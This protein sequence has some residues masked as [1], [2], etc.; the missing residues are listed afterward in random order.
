MTFNFGGFID[1]RRVHTDKCPQNETPNREQ[2]EL[3][4][5]G[6]FQ[7]TKILDRQV[8]RQR[9]ETF[10]SPACSYNF[11]VRQSGCCKFMHLP[12]CSL[13]FTLSVS[14][15][16]GSDNCSVACQVV[17]FVC[18]PEDTG[19]CKKEKSVVFLA[20]IFGIPLTAWSFLCSRDPRI[21]PVTISPLPLPECIPLQITS[22]E[23][24]HKDI[25][26]SSSTGMRFTKFTLKTLAW[27][28]VPFLAE[29]V[30]GEFT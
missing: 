15:W 26:T 13:P 17:C 16:N 7:V 23:G 28:I 11:F 8:L 18:I 22:C 4:V 12:F 21:N 5:R 27:V 24:W 14:T 30:N 9:N 20:I 25:Q 29:C 19:R 2:K 6:L 1:G 10:Q 3:I